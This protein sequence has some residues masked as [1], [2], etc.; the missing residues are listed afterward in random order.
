MRVDVAIV[1]AGTS[2]AAA[3]LALAR[4]GLRVACLERRPLSQAGARW[5]NGVPRWMFEAAGVDPPEGDEL[6]GEGHAFHLV[7]G[8]DGGRIVIRDHETL[9]VDMRH[10]VSRLQRL[11]REAGAELVGDAHVQGLSGRRLSTTRGEFE[12]DVFVDAA[13]MAGPNLGGAPRIHKHDL[14]VA[15]QEVRAVTDRA[16]AE[17]WFRERGAEPGDTLCF[18]GVAGGYSIVNARL[19]HEGIS[20]L[21]GS[22][23]GLGYPSGRVLL[24]RFVAEHSFVGKALFGGA[25][26]IPLG[27]ARPRLA[28]GRVALLGDSA[29]Q[30]FSAHGS[31][32]GSGMVAARVLADR[33]AAGGSDLHAYSV[34]WHR[35]HGG[36]LA[37][38]DVFRRFSQTLSVSDIERLMRAGLMDVSSALAALSQKM[39]APPAVTRWPRLVTGLVKERG[40][41]ARLLRV[42]PRLGLALSLYARYPERE[43]DVQA[44]QRRVARL[45]DV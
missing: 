43:K 42:A 34:A 24:E 21:T 23:P 3:A 6:R 37:A 45:L 20:L 33:V 10:L 7:A 40:L 41:A 36:V 39:P 28:M 13:G 19:D 15:A 29:L 27:R 11:A 44:W 12:A 2:G 25:R 18:T 14:C 9:D 38:Y 22:I 1:G 35:E 16:M 31:G 5:V 30:V 26:A 17:A 32:I 8:F 4:R